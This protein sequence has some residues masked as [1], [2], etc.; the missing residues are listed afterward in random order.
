M[1]FYGSEATG[2][3]SSVY[4][5]RYLGR[6]VSPFLDGRVVLWAPCV[7]QAGRESIKSRAMRS[8]FWSSSS[9]SEE[10]RSL[11]LEKI[12]GAPEINGLPLNTCT[13]AFAMNCPCRPWTVV[14]LACA[15]TRYCRSGDHT[16][17]V[18]SVDLDMGASEKWV[19]EYKLTAVYRRAHE[20]ILTTVTI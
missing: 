17:R 9:K 4:C 6:P 14:N 13:T 8:A 1:V 7:D 16:L 19:A 12:E 3:D 2:S 15:M 10:C 11:K 5:R 20:K 18:I